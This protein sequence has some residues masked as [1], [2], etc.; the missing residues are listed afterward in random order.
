MKAP[1]SLSLGRYDVGVEDGGGRNGTY[2]GLEETDALN[3]L[4]KGNANVTRFACRVDKEVR[5][6]IRKSEEDK[7]RG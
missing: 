2:G 3:F 1:H 4:H 6:W 5:V 7:T